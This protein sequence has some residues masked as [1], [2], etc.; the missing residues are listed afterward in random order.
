MG[1]ALLFKDFN[2]KLVAKVEFLVALGAT[3]SLFV[4]G[5]LA[6]YFALIVDCSTFDG[7]S[8]PW[9]S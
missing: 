7:A 4:F 9:D 3:R 2:A 6:S 1:I 8:L 5:S